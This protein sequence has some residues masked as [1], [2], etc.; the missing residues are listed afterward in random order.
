MWWSQEMATTTPHERRAAEAQGTDTQASAPIHATRSTVPSTALN[1]PL[2]AAER[3]K[4]TG[5]QTAVPKLP[6]NVYQPVLP[7]VALDLEACEVPHP[8][9][10]VHLPRGPPLEARWVAGR[11]NPAEPPSSPP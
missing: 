6:P 2:L 8:P 11:R 9:P 1:L 7:P 3:R 5:W 4:L 10:P